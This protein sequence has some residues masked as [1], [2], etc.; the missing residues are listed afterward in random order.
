MAWQLFDRIRGFTRS[1]GIYQQDR[2]LQDQPSIDKLISG[3]QFLDFNQ[4][5]AL[6]D[7][8]NLQINRLER[9][10]DYDQMDEVGEASLALDLYA[11]ESSIVDPEYKH[12]VIIKSAHSSVKHALEDLFHNRILIDRIIRAMVRYLVKYGDAPFE[13][14]PTTDRDGVAT[15]K[16]I[17]VYNFTRVE[18][19]YGDLVGFF[20]QDE[21]AAEPTF[22]HPWQVVHFRLTEYGNI[23]HPYG[24][25]AEFGTR[26][27]TPSGYKNIEDFKPGDDVYCFANNKLV[28][29]KVVAACHS[30]EKKILKIKTRHFENRCSENHPVMVRQW[31]LKPFKYGK[32]WFADLVYKRA[33]EVEIGDELVVP[34]TPE[35]NNY[36]I[37]GNIGSMNV[38]AD[39]K[40]ARLFGFLIGDGWLMRRHG[41]NT[42]VEF[43]NG[44]DSNLNK[45]YGELLDNYSP[46]KIRSYKKNGSQSTLVE[47]ATHTCSKDFADFLEKKC[48]FIQGSY[49]KRIPQWV[50]SSPMSVQKEF[51][52]GLID[53][54][55]SS[56]VDEWK[57]ER[58]QLELSNYELIKDVKMLLHK[59]GL[60]CGQILKRN[61]DEDTTIIHSQEYDRLD[62]WTIYFYRSDLFEAAGRHVQHLAGSRGYN[63][64]KKESSK[65][66]KDVIFEPV[67]SIEDGGTKP[68]ADIQVD[69]PASNFVA[70]GVVVHNSI[71]EGGRKAFKQL[72]LMEDAALIYRITR[73]PEKRLFSIPVGNIPTK[74]V[75]EYIQAIA[76]QFKN[77]RFYDPRTGEFN[78]RYS[79]LIQEDDFFL[80]KR[81]DGSGPAIDI[82]KGAENLDQIADIDYF[83][84]KMVAPMHIPFSRVGIGEG[85]GENSE[86][87]LASEHSQFAKAVQY[88]Q[89]EIAIGLQKVAICHLAMA[90]YTAKQ[91]KDFSITMTAT[92]AIDELYRI[93]TWSGRTRVMADLKDLGWFPDVWIVTRFTDLSPDEIQELKTME[94]QLGSDE[95]VDEEAL[96]LGGGGG[97]G[98]GIDDL[99]GA[100][101]G[102][103]LDEL[104]GLEAEGEGGE[105]GE[106][107]DLEDL[108]LGEKSMYNAYK[109]K[110]VLQEHK[111]QRKRRIIKEFVEKIRN[112]G[113]NNG[114]EKANETSAYENLRME[115]EF[116]GL[117]SKSNIGGGVL[118]EDIKSEAKE[119]YKKILS[120]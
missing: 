43:A 116:D 90:G 76:R 51:I 41:K 120:E 83:K 71:L 62:S 118:E 32:K 42:G 14:I 75:P 106:A 102:E 46:N 98:G 104:E 48:G 97:G 95:G 57:C 77:Q 81:P 30:G 115:N 4:Q 22:L 73:A 59:M 36:N 8:T 91:I 113:M 15:I 56:N 70:D 9:Y 108:G 11:D 74:E 82:L 86:K 67:V 61:R 109:E 44:V 5:Q 18:T 105:D 24:R 72:R 68:T 63:S 37:L 53:S 17:N 119:E 111:L 6:L 110:K 29:T 38:V 45:Y 7:Q 47:D 112:M 28:P 92:N 85:S 49:N 12:T 40:F 39:E 21:M 27:S 64:R 117:E 94:S 60:K 114:G 31:N 80:P 33:D 2:L 26:V 34:R 58:L 25:C 1:A 54:D 19:K 55:G 96:G 23:Y 100:E 13:I 88:V 16:F 69:H 10:K 50:Y 3:N 79:P 66:G 101:E 78:E 89:R 35:S 93:E 87:S 20:H 52:R 103:G 107:E 84:K 65:F 99:L